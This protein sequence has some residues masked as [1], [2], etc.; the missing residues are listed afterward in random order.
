M[1]EKLFASSWLEPT[2]ELALMT[3]KKNKKMRKRRSSMRSGFMH[4][5]KNI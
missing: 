2:Q 3:L 1:I 4:Q 5:K